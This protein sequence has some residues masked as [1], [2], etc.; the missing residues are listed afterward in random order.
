MNLATV[1]V[2]LSSSKDNSQAVLINDTPIIIPSMLATEKRSAVRD[3]AAKM[4][5]TL[6]VGMVEVNVNCRLEQ[7]DAAAITRWYKIIAVTWPGYWLCR[8]EWLN[9]ITKRRIFIGWSI[10]EI[11]RNIASK[12]LL[13][14]SKRCRICKNFSP[15]CSQF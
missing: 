10:L 4:A 7:F 11:W 2:L 14:K 5:E 6:S 1:V 8:A 9:S 3:I 12:V 13:P 15:N